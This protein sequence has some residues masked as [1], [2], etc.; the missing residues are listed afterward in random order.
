MAIQSLTWDEWPCPDG[1]PCIVTIQYDDAGNPP[2]ATGITVSKQASYRPTVVV[3]D[4]SG[5]PN[6]GKVVFGPSRLQQGAS[7]VYDI[8]ALGYSLYRDSENQVQVPFQ[9]TFS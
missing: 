2:P 4:D 6:E 7:Q 5:G 8:S 3:T 1:T 9:I